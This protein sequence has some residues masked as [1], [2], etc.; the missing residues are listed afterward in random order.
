MP[1]HPIEP[2]VSA[3]LARVRLDDA[4]WGTQRSLRLFDAGEHTRGQ[5]R[6]ERR[7][8]ARD[9]PFGHEHRHAEDVR[10]DAVEH[11][12]ALWNAAAVDH[13]ANRDAVLRHPVEDDARVECRTLDGPEQLVP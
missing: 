10:V 1:V 11:L 12:V 6:E 8:E 2:P 3:M 4:I 7:A 5:K 9:R 13:A